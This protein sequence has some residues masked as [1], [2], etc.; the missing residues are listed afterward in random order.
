MFSLLLSLCN[1]SHFSWLCC[2]L[3]HSELDAEVVLQ[4]VPV[5]ETVI[6]KE[7]LLESSLDVSNQSLHVVCDLQKTRY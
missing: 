6:A 2:D 3:N 7:Q 1:G 4:V 5:K